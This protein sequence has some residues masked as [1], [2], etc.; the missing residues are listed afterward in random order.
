MQVRSIHFVVIALVASLV[1]SACTQSSS[2]YYSYDKG[3]C[4]SNRFDDVISSLDINTQW[5][6]DTLYLTWDQ[7][8]EDGFNGYYLVRTEEDYDTCP[9]YF[10]GGDY[11]EYIGKKSQT[12]YK[13]ES[14]ESGATYYYRVC[15]KEQSKTIDCGGVKKITIY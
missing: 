3:D 7:Y 8:P 4:K 10:N 1:L 15:V 5:K 12:Y 11:H 14:I 13:D 2:Y 9:F 6:Y